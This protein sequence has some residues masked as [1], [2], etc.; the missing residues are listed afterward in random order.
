MIPRRAIIGFCMLCALAF[1]AFAAPSASAQEVY[2]CI[3]TELHN[4]DFK[5][6]HCKELGAHGSSEWGHVLVTKKTESST[7]N[8]TTGE[9]R[10]TAKLKSVQSGVTL[11]LQSTVVSG[12]G[13]LENKEEGA[14]TWAEGSGTGV[15]EN[16]TVTAPAGKGCEVEGGKIT[17]KKLAITSKGMANQLKYSPASG[18]TL[19]EFT[20]KGCAVTA[21]NHV[22]TAKGSVTA[23]TT[24][25]TVITSH[26][27]STIAKALTLSGQNAGITMNLTLRGENGNPLALTGTP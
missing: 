16:V 15:F 22:Y 11:E 25:P 10:S 13:A 1:S 2:T 12:S 7:A 9:E 24:G 20:I 17:T 8:I 21:L 26:E 14:T 6:A 18:E 3:K 5:D 23:S 27:V 4:G 19:A